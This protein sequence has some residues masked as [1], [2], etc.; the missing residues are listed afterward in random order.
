MHWFRVLSRLL[1]VERREAAVDNPARSALEAYAAL[2]RGDISGAQSLLTS[3]R[4]HSPPNADVL[5]VQGLVHAVRRELEPAA[6]SF[7]E[8]IRLREGFGAAWTQLGLVLRD[9][10]AMD[11]ALHAFET[12]ASMQ[13][14]T[15][16]IHQH[17][18]ITRYQSRDVPGAIAASTAALALRPDM[19]EARFVLAEALL[20]AGDFERGWAEYERRPHVGAA[21]SRMRAPR[22]N[23]RQS[24][25]RLA[26]V[27]E[28]GLGDVLMFA[29]LLPRLREHAANTGLFVQPALVE[30]MRESDLADHV[31]SVNEIEAAHGYD[32]HLPFMSLAQVLALRPHDLHSSAPYLRVAQSRLEVWRPRLVARGGTLRVGLAWGGNPSHA[33]DSDRSIPAAALAPL[34]EVRSASFYSLQLGRTDLGR[35]PFPCTDFTHELPN[36]ADTAALIEGLDLVI[37]V[38]SA[39]AHLTGA[40]GCPL[41]ALCPYRAD[42][43]WEIGGRESPWYPSAR[44]F[45]PERTAEWSPVIARVAE[46]L[47]AAAMRP[48]A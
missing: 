31:H 30:L 21:M 44:V 15:A 20:A 43:R 46:A 39:I 4:E 32:A 23:G 17:L 9:A 19:N 13:P 22:W 37:S 6:R 24:L 45:R 33:R 7:R 27:A 8:A 36:M 10:N 18:G 40:L 29:R 35:L 48:R 5:F 1:K 14:E 3:A 38:D 34:S 28:Q 41:W 16:E 25:A 12:A 47:T 26:V 2:N 11:E 42:W